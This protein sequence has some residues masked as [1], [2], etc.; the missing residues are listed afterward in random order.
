MRGGILASE[1]EPDARFVLDFH[2]SCKV[3]DTHCDIL[4]TLKKTN[5]RLN[6]ERA[7]G[8]LDLPRLLRGGV[9]VLFF[10]AFV[11]P[12]L[13][14]GYLRRTLELV[15]IFHNELGQNGT[16]LAPVLTREDLH[17]ALAAGKVGSLLTVE[18]G[19]ALEGSLEILQILHRLGVRALTLTWNYRNALGDGIAER[20]SRG[21]LTKFGKA[22]VREMNRIGM[23]VDVAHLAPAG[24]WDTLETSSA[25]VIASHC[26]SFTVCPHPRNLTD[27]QVRAI[28]D[29]GGV[30]SVTFV[31]DFVCTANPSLERLLDH[32]DHLVEIGGIDCVG[33]GSD[34]EGFNGFL[35]GLRDA[36]DLPLLT[37]GLLGRGYTPEE[38]K[39]IMGENVLRVL[40]Q[41]LPVAR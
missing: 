16:F 35:P 7:N 20:D 13:S 36:A 14:G 40:E 25:P 39:K 24:F 11:Q 38:V 12:D 22:V 3:V 21:G 17:D 33:I 15:A 23:L 18:G 1:C 37:R 34:F 30:V 4:D 26:N 29:A 27:D 41:V 8:H 2:K 19:E 6:Q 32:I 28:A 9:K 5:C 10:A 31:P